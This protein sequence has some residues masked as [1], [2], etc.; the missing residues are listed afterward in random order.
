MD[1]I[2]TL[3]N[4]NCAS[5]GHCAHC[6]WEA[7]EI[8]QRN[9]LL[10]ENGLTTVLHMEKLILPARKTEKKEAEEA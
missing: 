7:S 2:C 10:A 6:G 4:R 5:V 1:Y 9:K 3:P 8:E